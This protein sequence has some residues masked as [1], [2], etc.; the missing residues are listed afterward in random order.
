MHALVSRQRQI[1]GQQ[2]RHILSGL[3]IAAVMAFGAA[4]PAAAQNPFEPVIYVN[5]KAVTRYEVGQRQR[6][7]QI[8]GAPAL[9]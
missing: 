9:H 4:A 6:F 1:W 2:M 8:L 3:A 5:N 7:M